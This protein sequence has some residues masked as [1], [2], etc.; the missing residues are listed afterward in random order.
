MKILHINNPAAANGKSHKLFPLIKKQFEKLQLH[1][2]S[3]Q[4]KYAGQATEI[5]SSVDF[6]KYKCIAVS[7]GDG[8]LFEVVNGYMKNSSKNK[9]PI[10]PIPI[11]R[12][13]A[14]ARDLNFQPDN[15][16]N[17]LNAISKNEV[18]NS[19]VGYC[20]TSNSEFY[21]VNILGFGFVTDIAETAFKLRS[22]GHLSYVVGVIY[23]TINLKSYKL[24][25]EIDEK[26]IERDNVFVE[27]S[28]TKYTGKDFLMAPNAKIND[29]LLDITLLNKLSRKRVLQALP[30]IFT[31]EHIHMKEVETFKAKKIKIETEPKKTLTPDG[32]IMES[33]PIEIE[34]LPNAISFIHN[35]T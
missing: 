10:V 31:G 3:I 22:F 9:I 23:Q 34:C 20:K 13:N 26:V 8:S 4:T 14:F 1:H 24:K 32:Q 28:N 21:F 2:E 15:W 12:G 35:V 16:E 18:I 5:I 29:G 19:D 27:I 30:K 11:G 17:S 7:G 25:I 33:T 6:N